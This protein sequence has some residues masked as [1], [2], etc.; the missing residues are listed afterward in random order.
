MKLYLDTANLQEIRQAAE[1]GVIA[2][3]TTNP[4]LLAREQFASLSGHIQEICALVPE[5]VS[6]EV[7]ATAAGEIVQQGRELAKW[8]PKVVVKIP[9]TPDGTAA[10]R[11]LKAEGIPTNLTMI[12]NTNQGFLAA[13]AGADILCCYISRVDDIGQDSLQMIAD[14]A[15]FANNAGLSCEIMAASVR[16][17]RQV[18]ELARA[19]ADIATIPFA[20]L[21]QMYQHPLTDQ[22]LVKF[23]EDWRRRPGA[24]DPASGKLILR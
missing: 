24:V 3:V 9:L 5:T 15:V 11:R 6:V 10:T 16:Q 8:D 19:G 4:T 12:C 20:V 1:W 21:R 17:A 13:L 22:A 2:G 7:L 18:A 14:L 23:Q